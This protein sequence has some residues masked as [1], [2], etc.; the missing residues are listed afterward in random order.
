M[1]PNILV[2][3]QRA[4]GEAQGQVRNVSAPRQPTAAPVVAG[5]PAITA[6]LQQV[7]KQYPGLANNFNAQNTLAVLADGDR[8]QRGL[9]ERGGLEFWSPTENG[10]TDFPSPAPGKNV[11]EVY[12]KTLENNPAAMQQAI[13]GDLM[14]GMVADPYWSGLRSQ[15][16]QN[17]T[18]QETARQQ[19]HQTWWDDVNGSKG[20]AGDPT[21]DAY[22]RGWIADEGE[23]KKGQQ[24]SGGTMYSP[25]QLQELKQMQDYLNTGKAPQAAPQKGIVQP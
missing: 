8:A 11:L 7:L 22:I 3:L 24:E 12:D 19:Q 18:P 25:Q 17:F 13:Y 2:E 4:L 1:V 21:Y 16:M 23:G 6:V 20:S 9:K 5:D 15:F 10:T 14:H